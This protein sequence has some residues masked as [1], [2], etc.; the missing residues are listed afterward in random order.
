M[1]ASP[2]TARVTGLSCQQEDD[3]FTLRWHWT[4]EIEAVYIE[5]SAVD[6]GPDGGSLRLYTKAEYKAN[7]GYPGRMEG[8]G[9]Y[10]YTVYAC[11]EDDQGPFL[12]RQ[13][14]GEN[15]LA[16]SSGRARI[17][18][19]IQQKSGWFRSG[20]TIQIQ[21]MTEVPIGKD[22]LCYVK[23]Q[24]GYPAGKEDGVLYPFVSDFAPGRTV[25]PSF[26]IGKQDYVRLF[27]TNGQKY[28]QLYE[29]VPM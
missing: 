24:G 18:Y 17:Q 20:K 9:R 26:E 4:T 29:L 28:G 6:G 16:I 10:I 21:V 15:A 19:E 1:D 7:N 27:F 22:V 25:L 2:L 12:I 3:R 14:D 11:Q 13:T 5:R 8:I 23:K